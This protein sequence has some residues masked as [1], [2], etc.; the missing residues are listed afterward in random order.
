M[1]EPGTRPRLVLVGA[2]HTHIEI[3][4]R[5]AEADP[6]PVDLTVV[7]AHP[8]HHYS[9]MVPGYLSGM[10]S[11]DEISL[12]VGELVGGAGGRLLVGRA[13]GLDPA[14]R[15][16][17]VEGHGQVAY[18][19]V[20]VAVGSSSAGADD[21]RVARHAT[22]VKP[23][24]RVVDLREALRR[25]R[26]AEPAPRAALV[27]GGA[28]GIEVALA[29]ERVLGGGV[30]VY[31]SGDVVLSDFSNRFRRRL[32]RVVESRGLRIVTGSRVSGVEPRAVVLEDGSRREAHLT[33][34]LTGAVAFPWLAE[35][36]LPTDDRGFL[37]VDRALRSIADPRVFAAGDCATLEAEP[38][39]PKAGVY[40]VR[41]G[42]V[43][44]QSLRATV[45]G[46]EP[47]DY[48]P[49]SGFLA[50]LNTA[51]SKALLRYRGLVFHTRWALWLKDWIDRR[52]LN[53]YRVASR[54]TMRRIPNGPP[55]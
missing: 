13:V 40:A 51:D 10:Y 25:L 41:Q 4:R 6:L 16:V 12:D 54:A 52:F 47:P 44:W 8:R 19:L 27:G 42:P 1:P 14:R 33:A 55:G 20:S 3:L 39:V 30:T 49:Q 45:A 32:L 24:A 48:H 50:I 23:L 38:D 17:E 34:W 37:R 15:R 36:G 35:A 18:D 9:G 11:E 28:A 2:G 29:M 5:Q 7:S 26:E 22:R 53:R 31:E 21:P 46:G 43:L